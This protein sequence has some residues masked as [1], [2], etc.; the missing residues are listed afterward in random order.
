MQNSVTMPSYDDDGLPRSG[1]TGSDL[2]A[3]AERTR[4]PRTPFV[5]L[6]GVWIAVAV[7]VALLVA[8]T[9]TLYFVFG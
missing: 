5:A 8:V 2:A 7:V 6:A 4:T 1:C 9:L 3:D